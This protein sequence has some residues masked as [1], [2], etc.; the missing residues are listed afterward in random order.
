MAPKLDRIGTATVDRD[1]LVRDA[2]QLACAENMETLW[3]DFAGVFTNSGGPEYKRL[4]EARNGLYCKPFYGVIQSDTDEATKEAIVEHFIDELDNRLS[5]GSTLYAL[6]ADDNIC[7]VTTGGSGSDL[8]LPA[9]YV[10]VSPFACYDSLSGSARRAILSG[11]GGSDNL[12]LDSGAS[13]SQVKHDEAKLNERIE[14]V[15]RELKAVE[16]ARVPELEALRIEIEEKQRALEEK[17]QALMEELERRKADLAAKLRDMERDIL[18]LESEI[19]YIR[20]YTGEV[21]DL[22]TVRSGSSAPADCPIVISQKMRYMDEEL[23]KLASIYNVDFSD[24]A[25]FE[26]L[27]RCNDAAFEHFTPTARC[28]TLVRVSRSNRAYYGSENGGNVL[29]YTDKFRGDCIGILVRD[30]ENLYVAWTDENHISFKDDVFF[31]PGE[32]EADERAAR[33]SYES[34]ADYEK[35]LEELN[36]RAAR[37]ALGRAFVFSILQ[38]VV[39]R[40]IVALPEKVNVNKPSPY[41]VR[42]YADGWLADNRYGSFEDMVRRCNEKVSV[43]DDILTVQGLHA[44][45]PDWSRYA[46][47]TWFNDRGRG[48]RN[49][50]HDVDAQPCTIYPVNVVERLFNYEATLY[51][52]GDATGKRMS[53]QERD[54][55]YIAARKERF[56]RQGYEFRDEKLVALPARY[57][58]SLPKEYSDN[59][60]ANF[61]VYPEEFINLTYMNST[62]LEYILTTQKTGKIRIGGVTVDFAHLI[63]YLKRA[64]EYVRAREAKEREVLEGV[65]C[66]ILSSAEWPAILSEWKLKYGVRSILAPRTA[67]RFAAWAAEGSK[68]C[69]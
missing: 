14:D 63:P 65:G 17:K 26:K 18:R 36:A 16:E 23:G 46:S 22:I 66:G 64:L 32:T 54:E 51:L 12:S 58:I 56:E 6:Y 9:R 59:A 31:R 10:K 29:E 62:W 57:Y 45:R 33:M 68:N 47:P 8:L 40:G 11:S 7:L 38:G 67:K 24:T 19:Y 52:E 42:S 5:N 13:L 53:L 4:E 20:C 25:K 49:R 35:R 30:G 37:E 61:Q 48:E 21:V 50:T 28:V 34:D 39:D 27:L 3:K 43:G 15:S 69:E 60:R 1:A 44:E 41:I 2:K 55:K